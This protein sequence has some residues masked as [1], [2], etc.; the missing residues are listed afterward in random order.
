MASEYNMLYNILC[1]YRASSFNNTAC[2]IVV[3]AYYITQSHRTCYIAPSYIAH[4]PA[5][6]QA[7]SCYVVQGQSYILPVGAI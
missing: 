7:P 4:Q 1:Y 2:Y 6:Y 5:I 3:F